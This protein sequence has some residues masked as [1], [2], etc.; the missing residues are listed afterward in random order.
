M[1]WKHIMGGGGNSSTFA[2]NIIVYASQNV[3]HL[4]LS[5]TFGV[6]ASYCYFTK[7][8]LFNISL[9][10]Y[11][12]L[13]SRNHGYMDGMLS[14]IKFFSCFK[15]QFFLFEFTIH[16]KFEMKILKMSHLTF[17]GIFQVQIC[18]Q[19]PKPLSNNGENGEHVN[20]FFLTF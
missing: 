19:E 3:L 20:I 12:R 5:F 13:N 9:K 11:K 6:W 2:T 15:L 18:I 10:K 8:I 16:K 14:I 4:F 1:G 7:L 17:L